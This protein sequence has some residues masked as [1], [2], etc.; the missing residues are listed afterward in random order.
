MGRERLPR[1]TA[2]TLNLMGWMAPSIG[3][4]AHRVAVVEASTMRGAIRYECYHD[5][6]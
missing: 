5:R 1:V 6:D 4:E 2:F 3:V